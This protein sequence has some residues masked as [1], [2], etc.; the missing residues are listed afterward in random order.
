MI[1]GLRHENI[2][3][4]IGEFILYISNFSSSSSFSAQFYDLSNW[5]FIIWRQTN[6]HKLCPVHKLFSNIIHKENNNKMTWWRWTT[7]MRVKGFAITAWHVVFWVIDQNLNQKWLVLLYSLQWTTGQSF[8]FNFILIP[9]KKKYIQ[10][11]SRINH[12]FFI[13]TWIIFIVGL[14]VN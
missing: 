1:Y 4:F 11:I 5:F 13:L 14:C 8:L 2:N 7:K 9:N 10:F 3:P 6:T 12:I